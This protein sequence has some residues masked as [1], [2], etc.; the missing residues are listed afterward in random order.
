MQLPEPPAQLANPDE[1]RETPIRV[2]VGPVTSGGN[3]LLRIF[4]GVKDMAISI[5]AQMHAVPMIAPYPFGQGSGLLEES[6]GQ[7]PDAYICAKAPVATGIVVNDV[8]TTEI[9]PVPT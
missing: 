4:G 5:N 9:K 7:N 8:P 2:T 6:E 1:M 3:I